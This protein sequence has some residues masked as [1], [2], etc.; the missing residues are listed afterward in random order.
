[1]AFDPAL[2]ADSAEIIAAELRAQFN[3]LHAEIA[4][5]PAGP[6]GADGAPG[7]VT[8]AAL[9][10]AVSAAVAGTGRNPTSVSELGLAISDPPTQAEVQALAV[11][12]DELI[13]AARREP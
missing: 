10:A 12:L 13:A 4:A 2:P 8:T 5:V 11:K 6:P 3:G 1:M 9:S 7:E